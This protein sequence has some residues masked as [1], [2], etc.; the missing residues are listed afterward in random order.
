MNAGT[1]LDIRY[2]EYQKR[3]WKA[4]VLCQK[5]VSPGQ[6]KIARDFVMDEEGFG[7]GEVESVRVMFPE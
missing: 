2:R 5:K 6:Q 1:G 4:V 7:D 3:P